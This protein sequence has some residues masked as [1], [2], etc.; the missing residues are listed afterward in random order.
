MGQCVVSY[1]VTRFLSGAH[2]VE[3]R[4]TVNWST[5]LHRHLPSFI[6]SDPFPLPFTCSPHIMAF[7]GNPNSHQ[8][9]SSMYQQQTSSHHLRAPHSMS[10]DNNNPN[11]N[12]MYDYH[13]TN[14][15][16]RGSMNGLRQK[17]REAAGFPLR[18]QHTNN[19]MHSTSGA[20]Q[21][22]NTSIGRAS[23]GNRKDYRN[24]NINDPGFRGSHQR[25]SSYY[26]NQDNTKSSYGLHQPPPPRFSHQSFPQSS[27]MMTQYPQQ[28]SGP[29][30]PRGNLYEPNFGPMM[31]P[32]N[33]HQQQPMY[34]QQQ[35][36]YSNLADPMMGM[37]MGMGMMPMPEPYINPYQP[38]QHASM[39]NQPPMM[40]SSYNN[41]PMFPTMVPDQAGGMFPNT[42]MPYGNYPSSYHSMPYNNMFS[43]G[44]W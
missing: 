23:S 44:F 25:N 17:L 28:Q 4:F 14:K 10:F 9:Q 39:Y 6:Q 12:M 21:Y 30:M 18:E 8:Q 24:S 27:M 40:M 31:G 22:G 34:H 20:G 35:Q 26:N 1:K 5:D 29:I 38:M 33:M 7:S 43:T 11:S 2:Y 42:M 16:H 36:Y 37:G 19:G 32:Y 15:M 41:N 3:K 13:A